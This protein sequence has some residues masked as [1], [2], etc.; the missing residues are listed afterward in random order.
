MIPSSRR[1]FVIRL[2]SLATVASSGMALSACMGD[3]G[4]PP[5]FSYGVCSGDPLADRVMLWTHAQVPGMSEDV[6]LTYCRVTNQVS[7]GAR[8]TLLKTLQRW[9]AK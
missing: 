4:E 9:V 2:A 6:A 8:L 5:V 3:G 1:Q 7:V